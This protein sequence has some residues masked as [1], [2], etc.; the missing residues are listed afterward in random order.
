[1][2]FRYGRPCPCG[3]GQEGFP[4]TDA[5]GIFCATVCDACEASKRAKYRPEIFEDSQYEAD[6]LGDDED[7]NPTRLAHIFEGP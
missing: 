3:S 1:M 5:R 4:L 2:A 6:D 7:L